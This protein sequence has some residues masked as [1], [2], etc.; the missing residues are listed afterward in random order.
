MILPDRVRRVMFS[1]GSFGCASRPVNVMRLSYLLE[2]DCRRHY[3]DVAARIATFASDTARQ[4]EWL[5]QAHDLG[6]LAGLAYALGSPLT[7]CRSALEKSV[8]A[9]RE[10]FSRRG[11]S[12]YFHTPYRDG[13]PLPE[14]TIVEDGYTSR[15]SFRAVLTSLVVQGLPETQS[16]VA[17]AGSKPGASLVAP[18]SEVCTTNEQT[19]SEALNALVQ[20]DRKRAAGEARKL[21]V[22][23]GS[24]LDK[25]TAAAIVTV[26]T[27]GNA[28]GEIET[29]LAFHTR[30]AKARDRWTDCSTYLCLPALGLASLAIQLGELDPSDLDADALYAPTALL[31]T[32]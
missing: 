9:Y 30:M 14:E 31:R 7:D 11:T 12:H 2:D 4:S 20:E 6:R 5:F 32:D 13:K 28:A 16:L 8:L 27:G 25:Q 17:L 15:D 3:A 1:Q 18:Q 22:R 26:A 19:I 10:I 24:Q 21:E 23:K 29:L